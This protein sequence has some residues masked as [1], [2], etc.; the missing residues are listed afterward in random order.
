MMEISPRAKL[1]EEK[2]L[3][4]VLVVVVVLSS[5]KALARE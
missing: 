4:H 5:R 3:L 1:E 2:R